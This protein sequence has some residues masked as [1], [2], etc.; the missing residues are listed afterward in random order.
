MTIG[1]PQIAEDDSRCLG[2]RLIE[3]RLL[4]LLDDLQCVEWGRYCLWS[5]AA[6]TQ[7]AKAA[8]PVWARPRINAWTSWV[9]S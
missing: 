8:M 7:L 6:Q 5:R 2:L 3:A 9:P 1:L 4:E